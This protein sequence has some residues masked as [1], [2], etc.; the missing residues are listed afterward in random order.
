[1]L[2]AIAIATCRSGTT[3]AFP[4]NGFALRIVFRLLPD[5]LSIGQRLIAK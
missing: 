2:P 5:R 1:M 4:G 3:G